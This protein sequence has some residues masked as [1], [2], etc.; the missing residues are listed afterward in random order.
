MRQTFGFTRRG[1]LLLAGGAGAQVWFR[2][3]AADSTFWNK[4][5]PAEWSRE[6]IDK[7]TTRSPWAKEVSAF[8]SGRGNDDYSPGGTGGGRGG[9]GVPGI[10]TGRIGGMGTPDWGGG[11][12]GGGM[13]GG[14]GRCGRGGGIP[15][16]FKGV[17]RWES[18]KPIQEALKTPL[19]QS[20]ANDY[21][22]SVNGIPILSEHRQRPDEDDTGVAV[23]KAPSEEVLDRI[24]SLTYLEP[25]GKAPAQPGVVQQGA[26]S[27]GE[28]NTLWF[29]FSR[30]LLQLTPADREVTFTTQL[31][32]LQVK[33]KFNL[34]DMM[35]HKELAL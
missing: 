18:A 33:T 23:S 34:K 31:G 4:K 24:K 28:T 8:T 30:E 16:D 15:M 25:K 13:G 7:L 29:G 17:V 20:L 35:Y 1:V 2:L 26:A 3:Y 21:V 12:G 27:H 14:R 22:I 11:M 5:E 32:R 9:I 10:G 6:E 19:P